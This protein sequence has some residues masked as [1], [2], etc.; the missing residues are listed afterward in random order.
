MIT[1]IMIIKMPNASFRI[2]VSAFF[3][4]SV[5]GTHPAMSSS[6]IG[7]HTRVCKAL[8]FCQVI[9]VL[10]KIL[11]NRMTGE[12]SILFCAKDMIEENNGASPTPQSPFI[13]PETSPAKIHNNAI[14]HLSFSCYRCR[15]AF[16]QKIYGSF[17]TVIHE[18][19]EIRPHS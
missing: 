11:G 8:R 12:I 15:Y 5:P 9:R 1:P 7:S 13:N 3:S 17:R 14:I 18:S 16:D 6:A 19:A 10:L 2:P 4:K